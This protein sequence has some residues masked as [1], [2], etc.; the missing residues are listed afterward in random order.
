MYVIHDTTC[1][2]Y[3]IPTCALY[4]LFVIISLDPLDVSVVT[5][6]GYHSIIPYIKKG[7][8]NFKILVDL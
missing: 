5:V 1:T 6:N 3:M 4:M 2:L 8:L 7:Y